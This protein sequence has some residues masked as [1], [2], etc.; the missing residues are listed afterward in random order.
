[1][2]LPYAHAANFGDLDGDCRQELS[3][4]WFQGQYKRLKKSYVPDGINMG[5]NLG[6]GAGA[7][8]RISSSC[9]R[10]TAD[11]MVTR[12]HDHSLKDARTPGVVGVDSRTSER[13]F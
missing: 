10:V 12:I 5:A 4:I 11:G 3:L 8:I 7:G 1:M 9:S 6:Q 13:C 2:V